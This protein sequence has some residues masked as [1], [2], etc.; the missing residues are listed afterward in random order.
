[1]A[2]SSFIRSTS[3]IQYDQEV[4]LVSPDHQ[5][6][7]FC[8][9]MFDIMCA[10]DTPITHLYITSLSVRGGLGDVSV[11]ATKEEVSYNSLHNRSGRWECV[12]SG[13]LPA[14][15]RNYTELPFEAPVEISKGGTRAFYIH[16]RTPG[17]A[18]IVYDNHRRHAPNADDH[19]RVLPGMAHLGIVPFSDQSQFGW[20]AW[21]RNREFVGKVGYGTRMI[22]WRRNVHCQFPWHWRRCAAAFYMQHAL[23]FSGLPADV[24][25]YVLNFCG[26]EWFKEEETRRRTM[27]A[28]AV[29]AG[30]KQILGVRRHTMG[31]EGE[32][33]STAG[34]GDGGVVRR[35]R[36][37]GSCL[38]M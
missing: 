31:G 18:S 30:V 6:H 34:G 10:E 28:G 3:K 12:F 7:T 5:D 29:A 1:M 17:D 24:V 25:E 27:S 26:W 33:V 9:I 15:W 11:Y 20:G 37:S 38:L 23:S 8:G 22:L 36:G 16:S 19:L 35:R 32:M 14:S 13:R 21:R 2:A 4:T